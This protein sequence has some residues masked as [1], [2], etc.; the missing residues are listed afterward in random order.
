MVLYY[1]VTHHKIDSFSNFSENY[2][3]QEGSDIHVSDGVRKN[4]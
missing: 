1:M 4:E 3:I 2:Y